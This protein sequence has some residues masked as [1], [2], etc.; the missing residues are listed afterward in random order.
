MNIS[1]ATTLFFQYG[2]VG[3]SA[4]DLVTEAPTEAQLLAAANRVKSQVDE[5][6]RTIRLFY[7]MPEP[8]SCGKTGCPKP[9][10]RKIQ[11]SLLYSACDEHLEEITHLVANE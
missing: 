6:V 1:Q 4:N 8:V 10:A 7:Q 3:R 9:A 5:A 11:G 2:N